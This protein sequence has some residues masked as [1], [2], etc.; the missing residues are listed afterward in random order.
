[1][2]ST[3]CL[4]V[5]LRPG[6]RPIRFAALLN[7]WAKVSYPGYYDPIDPCYPCARTPFAQLKGQPPHPLVKPPSSHGSLSVAESVVACYQSARQS[8]PHV[9]SSRSLQA[10]PRTLRAGALQEITELGRSRATFRAMF[11]GQMQNTAAVTHRGS[12]GGSMTTLTVCVTT[13]LTFRPLR[14]VLKNG[15]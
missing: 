9:L 10:T 15:K 7:F 11:N 5:N 6:A 2:Q 4:A 8:Q 3:F 13:Y 1:M 12:A 14:E